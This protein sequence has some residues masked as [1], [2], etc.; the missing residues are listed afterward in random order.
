MHPPSIA[1]ADRPSEQIQGRSRAHS[2]L[3]PVATVAATMA[4]MSVLSAIAL[5]IYTE[6]ARAPE[7]HV[8]EI[9]AGTSQLIAAGENPLDIPAEW[10]FLADDT[11]RLVNRDRVDHWIGSFFVPA[12]ETTD[13]RLHS[14]ISGSLVCSVHP[15]GTI[16]IR[17]DARDFDWRYTVIPTF[18]LGPALGLV[19][20]AVTRIVGG[21]D[22][23][24]DPSPRSP[25]SPQSARQGASP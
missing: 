14:S 12:F 4:A 15:S 3:R 22:D 20:V 7:L 9:P 2:L 11:L 16:D 5:L 21:L 17:V 6:G 13:Y 10:S 18:V 8:L 23:P 19:I 25:Q 24:D 1:G